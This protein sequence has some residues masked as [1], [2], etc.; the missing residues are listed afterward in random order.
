ML[1]GKGIVQPVPKK[2]VNERP[3]AQTIAVTR[4]AKQKRG[5]VHILHAAS[6][7]ARRVA[8]HDVLRGGYDRLRA[9]SADPVDGHRG[10][11]DRK[12]RTYR[13]LTRRVHSGA[14]LQNLAHNNGIDPIR[15]KS[16][17]FQSG[18]DRDRA[19]IGRRDIFQAAAK[20][21]D[22]GA[23]RRADN[24]IRARHERLH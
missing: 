20:G 23:H 16:C 12:T 11:V 6:D 9:G 8:K 15:C 22:G 7:G 17:P 3:V 5:L 24:R 14:G 19:K 10:D 1:A 4:F 13:C 18:L 2:T 21:A